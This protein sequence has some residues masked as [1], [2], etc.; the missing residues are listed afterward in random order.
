MIC[1]HPGEDRVLGE[2]VERSAD[3]IEVQQVVQIGQVSMLPCGGDFAKPCLICLHEKAYYLVS[4]FLGR[5][6]H[7][8]LWEQ[9]LDSLA[10][11]IYT[12]KLAY[13]LLP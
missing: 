1:Q 6:K 13:T 11:D 10:P 9:I 2:V 12:G 7:P 4:M 5:V 3:Q 8:I